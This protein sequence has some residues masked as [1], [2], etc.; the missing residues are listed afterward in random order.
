MQNHIYTIF[1][2]DVGETKYVPVHFRLYM[3]NCV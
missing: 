2:K 3:F 1:L